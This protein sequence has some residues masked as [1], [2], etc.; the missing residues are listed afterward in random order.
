M[1][2]LVSVL[3]NCQNDQINTGQSSVTENRNRLTAVRTYILERTLCQVS[4]NL[5]NSSYDIL[6]IYYRRRKEGTYSAILFIFIWIKLYCIQW[7]LL[8][9]K[10]A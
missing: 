2:S 1:P 5:D 3:K 10:S 9:S 6:Q 4:V 8:A 7:A